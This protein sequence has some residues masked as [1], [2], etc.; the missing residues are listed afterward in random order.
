MWKELTEEDRERFLALLAFPEKE[1]LLSFLRKFSQREDLFLVGGAV[2]DFL[3][4]KAIHDLDIA[5]KYE[6]EALQT[7][8]AKALNYTSVP[9]S[10]EFGIFRLSK[11]AFTLDLTLYRGEDIKEDLRERDFTFNAIAIPLKALF[12]GPFRLYDPFRGEKDLR[13]GLIRALGEKNIKDDPLRILRGYRFLA[14]GYGSLTAET[15][16]IFRKHREGLRQVAPERISMELKYILLTPQAGFSF[17][18]M[19]KDGVLEI[20]FPEITPCIGLPQPSFHHLDVFEH[21]LE[22]LR[23][24]DILLI[25]PGKHL[26][27]EEEPHF[28]KEE[29]FI[30]AVKLGSFFHDL[31]KGYTYGETEERITFY[32]HEKVGAE[33][34]EKRAKALRFKG[35]I[36]ERVKRLIQNHMRP[37]HLLREWEEGKLSLRAK[38][39]LI[40][41][42]PNIYELWLVAL[43]D[44]LASKGPDKEP[45]YEEKLNAFF[46]ELI[47]FQKELERVEKRERLL[48]GKDLISLG[49]SPSPLFKKILEEIELKTLSG[50]IKTKDEAITYVMENYGAGFR[51]TEEKAT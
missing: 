15:R 1:L 2:R 36:I 42:Q 5:V 30:L 38:R 13:E 29:D 17:A 37:C 6:P 21:G 24:A 28:L 48:T 45:D 25:N 34:W 11:G 27:L 12:E 44:S 10:P 40:K 16:A 41:D 33:L 35:E 7:F 3:V 46:K 8:L 43:A 23:Q 49:F 14:Q 50:E 22:A 4:G 32:G 51:G 39:N 19:Q 9:L 20:L 47:A 18:E 26:S 31:G